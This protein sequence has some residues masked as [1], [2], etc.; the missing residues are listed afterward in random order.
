MIIIDHHEH[1]VTSAAWSPDSQAIVTGSLDKHAQLRTQAADGNGETFNWPTALRT[2]DC[3]ITPDGRK[4]IA[5]STDNYITV[6]NFA[7]RT[8]DYAIKVT[9]RMTCLSVSQDSKHMLVNMANDEVHL[10]DI[11]S[12]KLVRKYAGQRQNDFIIRSV[13]GGADEGLIVSGS[14]GMPTTTHLTSHNAN[15]ITDSKV[16][17]WHKENGTLIESLEGHSHGCVNTVAWNPTNPKMF[18]SGGD[19]K[20]VRIWTKKTESPALPRSPFSSNLTHRHSL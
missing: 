15:M 11:A 20:K 18:A 1:P 16:Y 8:E 5:M 19:D 2:Q 3:A 4:L 12:A 10:I 9:Q 6:Y 13:F 17:I 7:D 14:S